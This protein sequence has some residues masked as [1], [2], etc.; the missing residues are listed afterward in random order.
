M[1]DVVA[2]ALITGGLGVAGG[3]MTALVSLRT[4]AQQRRAERDRLRDEHREADRRVR[5]DA[6]ALLLIAI[7]QLDMLTS[8]YTP[9]PTLDAFHEFL[10]HFRAA[11]VAVRLVDSP[12]V[13][14]ARS[15]FGA[16]LDPSSA[17][18]RRTM[19]L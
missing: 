7:E 12:A 18:R 13:R 9:P 3:A 6:Y 10:A 15:A 5:R 19:R 11:G 2:I 8:A 14:D 17:V 16:V 1:T 4:G